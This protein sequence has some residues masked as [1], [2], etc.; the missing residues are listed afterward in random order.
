MRLIEAKQIAGT[1]S[2]TSK[3]PC[4]S[5]STSAFNCKTGSKLAEIPGSVC[6]GCY[7]RKGFYRM[8]NVQKTLAKRLEGI[9]HPQWV[10]AM[11]SLIGDDWYF[12]WHDSGD[13]QSI[14]HLARI[15]RV[16]EGT[17]DCKHWLPTK[18]KGILKAFLRNGGVIPENLIVRLSGA[19]IDDVPPKSYPHTSTVHDKTEGWGHVC[20]AYRQDGKCGDCRACWDTTVPNVSYPKH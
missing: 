12:R 8:P 20:P 9:Q 3:M 4:K 11:V 10:D 13:I 5:T 17:P 6:H 2:N 16:A 1:L 14:E 18:E 15:C 19:M 7:A